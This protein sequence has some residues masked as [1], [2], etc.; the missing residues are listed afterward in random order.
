MEKSHYICSGCMA[1]LPRAA[2]HEKPVT[3][4]DKRPVT[5]RCKSCRRGRDRSAET[6]NRAFKR[7]GAV[8]TE[9]DWPAKLHEGRCDLCLPREG[10]RRCTKCLLV[11][12]DWG[13]F[14]S[15][16]S[17]C[18]ECEKVHGKA[19]TR[20]LRSRKGLQPLDRYLRDRY[21]ITL[22]DYN[23]RLRNQGGV[24]AIC[25][26]V[27]DQRRLVVDH[28][29]TTGDVRGLLCSRCNTGLG[30]FT[31]NPETLYVAA[32]YLIHRGEMSNELTS[33]APPA[34]PHPSGASPPDRP[35]SELHQAGPASS[36]P[37]P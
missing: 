24:C 31:D 21:G 30:M 1:Q 35:S 36:D 34:E 18:L 6:W 10:L 19:R 22:D 14:S 25:K 9:C 28:C 32:V 5:Y 7:F 26:R 13:D 8:C 12:D 29:H 15:N 4:H 20:R 11:K 17:F 23:E 37:G 27:P 3:E 33:R 16:D 2:F